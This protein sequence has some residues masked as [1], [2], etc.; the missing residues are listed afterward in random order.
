MNNSI[1]RREL[2]FKADRCV[3]LVYGPKCDSPGQDDR[4]RTNGIIGSMACKDQ[5][6]VLLISADSRNPRLP[7]AE[8]KN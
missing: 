4:K 6:A 7:L 1:D 5:I 8:H 3:A 2:G